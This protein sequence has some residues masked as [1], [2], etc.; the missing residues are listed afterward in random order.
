MQGSAPAPDR[1][2]SEEGA[3][4]S[5]S[6]TGLGHSWRKGD[7]VDRGDLGGRDPASLRLQ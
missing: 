6:C 2:L 3:P 7:Q 4:R 1:S 5:E